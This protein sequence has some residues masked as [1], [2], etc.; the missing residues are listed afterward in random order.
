MRRHEEDIARVAIVAF[1]VV[2]YSNVASV[3]AARVGPVL[4]IE[5]STQHVEGP[6][7]Q[8]Q[9]LTV[10][11]RLMA[12]CFSKIA[13]P[14]PTAQTPATPVTEPVDTTKLELLGVKFANLRVAEG[15]DVFIVLVWGHFGLN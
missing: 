13:C 5:P 10:F 6:R 7:Q 11:R 1:L 14:L 3:G 2:G 4:G 8:S 15:T 9:T 12:D